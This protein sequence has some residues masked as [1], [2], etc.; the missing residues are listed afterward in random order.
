MS[1][2][3]RWTHGTVALDPLIRSRRVRIGIFGT[4]R[5]TATAASGIVPFQP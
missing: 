2:A 4:A 1:T 5:L 3:K